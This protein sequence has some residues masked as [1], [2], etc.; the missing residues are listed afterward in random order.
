ME[1]EEFDEVADDGDRTIN[2]AK[3]KAELDGIAAQVKQA[4]T[5]AGIDLDV[6]L[7]VPASGDAIV[8]FGTLAD[9]DQELWGHVANIVTNIVQE[10]VGLRQAWSREI[11]CA[12]TADHLPIENITPSVTDR[13]FRL[14]PSH[15]VLATLAIDPVD[16]HRFQQLDDDNPATRILSHDDPLDGQLIVRVACASEETRQRLEHGWG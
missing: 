4:L 10:K 3:A 11:M 2:R 6:F 16:W 14:P 15:P 9:P 8:T 5:D 1:T 12:T 7:L 13:R